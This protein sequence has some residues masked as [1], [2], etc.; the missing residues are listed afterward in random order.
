[1]GKIIL[2]RHGQDEDNA[3]GILNGRRDMPLTSLGVSQ[4]YELADKLKLS[5]LDIEYVFSSPYQRAE[6][7]AKICSSF[8]DVPHVVLECLVERNHGILE[9]HP[10]SDIPRLAKAFREVHG[11]TYVLEVEGGEGYPELYE[12]ATNALVEIREKILELNIKRDVLIVSH[13][14]IGRTMEAVHKGLGHERMFELTSPKNCEF[15][16]LE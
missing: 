10:Y 1:M 9:G 8:L 4:A 13:G 6:K 7:T 12:R 5:K 15:R 16:I 3:R 14:A 11:M 2:A